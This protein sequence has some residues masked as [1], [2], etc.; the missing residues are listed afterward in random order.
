MFIV[1]SAFSYYCHNFVL[2]FVQKS[3]V[4]VTANV[5]LLQT[6]L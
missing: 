3:L 5:N 2:N 1:V 6:V 4:T